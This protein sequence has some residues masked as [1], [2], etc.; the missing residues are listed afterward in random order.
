MKCLEKDRTRRYE[1]ANSLAGDIGRYLRDEP[2]EACPPSAAYRFR[3]FVRRQKTGLVIASVLTLA[4]L[5]VVA[6]VAG[7]I[8][9]AVRERALPGRPR[10][11][12]RW[13]RH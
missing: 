8:G 1:T 11:K 3:K 2:V 9:W 13:I 6:V 10:S 4:L 5:I 12:W 7:S